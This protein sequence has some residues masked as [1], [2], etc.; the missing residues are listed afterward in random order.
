[1]AK[2]KKQI[3]EEQLK[4]VK[5]QQGKLNGLLRSL[6]VLDLQKENIRVEV[7][8]VSEEIDSTKKELEDEYGQVNIDLQDGSYTDIE[9]E[10]GK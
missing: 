8:K 5:D 4:T 10:D 6:G 2:A 1:M 7:N 3:T 9:K